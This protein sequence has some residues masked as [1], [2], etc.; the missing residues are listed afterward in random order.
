MLPTLRV[1]NVV[2]KSFNRIRFL[3][4]IRHRSGRC[5][6]IRGH[7]I[8]HAVIHVSIQ[9][10]PFGK[11]PVGCIACEKSGKSLVQPQIRPPLGR[12]Q[13]AEPLMSVFMGNCCCNAGLVLESGFGFVEDEGVF[14]EIIDITYIKSKQ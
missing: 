13:I 4:I 10:I 1:S 11:N 7:H 12:H 3:D 5:R 2:E 14:A 8:L 6:C 9:D